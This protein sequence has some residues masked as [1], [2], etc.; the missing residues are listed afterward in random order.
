MAQQAAEAGNVDQKT[1]W[2]SG[3]GEKWIVHE[4]QHERL[5]ESV[6][7][8]LVA[9]AGPGPGDGI[10]EIGCGTGAASMVFAGH[11]GFDGSVLAVDI[12][13]LLLA[14]AQ[15]R[16]VRAG[17]GNLTALLADAQVLDFG[18]N[19]FDMV[20]SRFGT[21]FFEDPVR[22]F[23]NIRRALRKRGRLCMICWGPVVNNPWFTVPRDAA[24]ARLGKPPPP[25]PGAPGPLA[26]ADDG[27]V[28]DI[29]REAGFAR[30]T[31]EK[32]T[33]DLLYRGTAHE[34]ATLA[35]ALGPA[36]RVMAAFQGGPE[37][38]AVIIAATAK[39]FEAYQTDCEVRLPVDIWVYDA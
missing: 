26:F 10:L 36:A 4:D 27:Y 19:Q 39:A 38:L 16:F 29:L 34:G 23:A 32:V 35:C 33:I 28:L 17:L 2:S 8:L 7:R 20:V 3:P 9:R 5:T 22:A 11:V 25:P 37:D 21:M 12:S 1:Y 14:R 30:A 24:F 31:A 15:E 13:D 18:E 6:T